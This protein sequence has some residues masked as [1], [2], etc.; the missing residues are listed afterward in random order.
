MVDL[1]AQ[2][3]AASSAATANDVTA[4]HG[5]HTGAEAM[6]ALADKLGWLISALHVKLRMIFWELTDFTR[7]FVMRRIGLQVSESALRALK[8]IRLRA[9]GQ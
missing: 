3:L 2:A 6:A 8:Y 4:T 9:Y 5:G 1:G 7:Y